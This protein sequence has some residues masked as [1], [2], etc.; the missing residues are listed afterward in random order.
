MEVIMKTPMRI[1]L[2]AAL[3]T[4]IA[5]PT[6]AI[7]AG[8]GNPGHSSP[9]PSPPPSSPAPTHAVPGPLVGAGLPFIAV[10]YG[11]YWLVRR[12]RKPE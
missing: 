9:P 11:V 12:R 5:L 4:V 1:G 2:W 3:L 8:P 10:G 7:A 6:L